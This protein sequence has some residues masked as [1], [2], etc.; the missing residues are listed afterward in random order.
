MMEEANPDRYIKITEAATILGFAHYRSVNQMIE[1]GA[2]VGYRLRRNRRRVLQARSEERP[3]RYRKCSCD[4]QGGGRQPSMVESLFLVISFDHF[5]TDIKKMKSVQLL[6]ITDAPLS[7]VQ[8]Q[9][10][11]FENIRTMPSNL[12]LP[13]SKRRRI[14]M[15]IY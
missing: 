10:S 14:K 3:K 15:S 2:L 12:P 13:D 4:T 8:N 11:G 9:S 5:M 7:R 6:S 1:R